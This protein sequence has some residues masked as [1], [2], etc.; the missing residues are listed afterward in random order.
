M[1]AKARRLEAVDVPLPFRLFHLVALLGL[2]SS[3]VAAAF[4][5]LAQAVAIY[6]Y[7]YTCGTPPGWVAVG[8]ALLAV[9]TLSGVLLGRL[10]DHPPPLWFSALVLLGFGMALTG[11]YRESERRSPSGANLLLIDLANT[12]LEFFRTLGKSQKLK[13]EQAPEWSSLIARSTRESRI[14]SPYRK[15]F[16]QV[17]PFSLRLADKED[18][19]PLDAPPGTL[20][21]WLDPKSDAFSLRVIG[22]D[23]FHQPALLK[24][25]TGAALTLRGGAKNDIF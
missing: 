24:D 10:F 9:L 22:L 8:G 20:L 16:T 7:P 23:D 3:A 17:V 2:T 6:R 21:L 5:E 25:E 19:F 18:E 11:L 4:P 13:P 15:G 14:E 12:E 1:S